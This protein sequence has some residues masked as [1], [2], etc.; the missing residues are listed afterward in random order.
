MALRF[1]YMVFGSWRKHHPPTVEKFIKTINICISTSNPLHGTSYFLG[2]QS[3]TWFLLEFSEIL[4]VTLSTSLVFIPT[5][6]SLKIFY[7]PISPSDFRN[8]DRLFYSTPLLYLHLSP[9]PHFPYFLD[10]ITCSP[11]IS[12][13]FFPK[14]YTLG[15]VSFHFPSFC[16]YYTL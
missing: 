4:T 3:K 1:C 6:V 7:F 5:L 15:M 9:L 16:S 2:K 10:Q 11:V 13:V 8:P 12:L 14:P